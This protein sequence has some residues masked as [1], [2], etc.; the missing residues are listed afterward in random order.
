VPSQ[1]QLMEGIGRAVSFIDVTVPR[2]QRRGGR[3][4]HCLQA[5]DIDSTYYWYPP[6]SSCKMS[7]DSDASRSP[8]PEPTTPVPAVSEAGPSRPAY[9]AS[10]KATPKTRKPSGKKGKKF[11]E[12]KVRPARTLLS[13]DAR[14]SAAVLTPCSCCRSQS[15]LLDLIEQVAGK[16]DDERAEKLQ[17]FVRCRRTLCPGWRFS[18]SPDLFAVPL[19][20]QRLPRSMPMLRSRRRSASST[21]RRHSYVPSVEAGQGDTCCANL[22]S[23]L[24]YLPLDRF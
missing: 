8:S 16:K 9:H 21:G 3:S 1:V 11:V 24:S 6:S 20:R 7:S 5:S 18:A 12:E 10:R 23:T 15:S 19:C 2:Q 4:I 17:K 14:L 22:T 13:M